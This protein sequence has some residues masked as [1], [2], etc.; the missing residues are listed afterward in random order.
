MSDPAELSSYH[1]RLPYGER[2]SPEPV[3]GGPFFPF[4]GDLSVV[5]LADPVVPESPR[6]GEPGGD[7]CFR[8]TEPDAHVI[9][10]DDIWTVR[11]GFAEIGLPMV[12]ALAPHDHVTLHSMPAAIAASMGP[13]IQRLVV[14]VGQIEGVG[15]T[16]FSRWGDG[17]EH[18]HMWFLARPLGMMQMRGAMLAVWDDLL[19]RLPDEEL[20]A[21]I[22]TVATVLAR[23]G[24]EAVGAGAA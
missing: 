21:N 23:D 3:A 6:V 2:M 11:C 9:W 24:G 22:R 10:R 20:A 5:P 1:A 16:H 4:D 17:S 14:A 13:M 7:T 18:F 8:C 19:P 12:A 15:R